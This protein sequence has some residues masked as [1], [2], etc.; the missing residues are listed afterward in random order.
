[1]RAADHD[2]GFA[3]R[4]RPGVNRNWRLGP[5]HKRNPVGAAAHNTAPKG[6]ELRRANDAE[7]RRA[8][9]TESNIVR[10]FD[11]TGSEFPRAV[12]R[13]DQ[14]VAAASYRLRLFARGVFP[15]NARPVRSKPFE[16]I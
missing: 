11:A 1:M 7:Q 6:A 12:E 5:A 8:V 9:G 3:W 16:A 14:K 2:D 10:I 4:Q 13:V 15:R